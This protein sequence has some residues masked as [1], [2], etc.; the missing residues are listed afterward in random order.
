MKSLISLLALSPFLMAAAGAQESRPNGAPAPPAGVSPQ[1]QNLLSGALHGA[2]SG[3]PIVPTTFTPTGKSLLAE[4]MLAH[5]NAEEAQ[6]Q[7]MRA[8]VTQVSGLA[9][10]AYQANGFARNDLGVALAGLLDVCYELDQGT[11]K[12]TPS[13]P[14]EAATDKR[15]IQAAARQMQRALGSAPDFKN[16]SDQ[17]RQLAYEYCAF[18]TGHLAVNWQQAGQ[19]QAKQKAVRQL[20]RQQVQTLFKLS[21]ESLSRNAEGE[22]VPKAGT[23]P[24]EAQ[25]IH[26]P[27]PSAVTT[28]T[29]AGEM[30]TS[31]SAGKVERG[32]QLQEGVYVGDQFYGKE[33]RDRYR[34]YL[35][36][37]GQYRIYD[38]AGKLLSNNLS[39]F[40]Y[41]PRTG[42]LD[43][44]HG[45]IYMIFNGSDPKE[46]YCFYGRADGKPFVVASSDRGFSLARVLLQY[47][48]PVDKPSPQAEE[49]AKAAAEA[50]AKRYKWV[51][52]AGQGLKPSQV[53][54][55][56]L[57]QDLHQFYNGSG[58]SV[59]M[60]YDLYL[61]LNDGT[62]Y[63]GLP[64]SP[65]EMDVSLSRRKEPEKW[66][67]WKR[68]GDA[69]LAAWP[70]APNQFKPIKGI[71]VKPGAAGQK[72]SGRFGAGESSGSILGSS[73]RL[74]GVTFTPDGHFLKDNRGGYGS[75]VTA[76]NSGMAAIHS[77]YDDN[78]SSASASGE[79]FVVTS[80]RKQAP[81]GD[82]GGTYTLD[83]YTLTLHYD[84][85]HTARLPF[86]FKDEKQAEIWFEG[87]TLSRDEKAEKKK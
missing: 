77:N 44:S 11:F 24:A 25:P 21:P 27:A 8:Y 59:S 71:P 2:K 41:D 63:N 55:I 48:G 66:G 9:E 15:R 37:D 45:R 1:L 16:I 30:H 13:S 35:Y 68:Q 62:V 20:A 12:L 47:E 61:L 6:K 17:N 74:W 5:L 43:L 69:Y 56:L 22:F 64:V 49:Q 82:R 81:N 40:E 34:L 79:H 42:K 39:T 72:L 70:D 51:V 31:P 78:G 54:G 53:A 14:E 10:Q 38:K 67:H 32:G 52:P 3:A 18:M 4:A 75:S 85:G 86:F 87:N 23:P 26:S 19:D 50:E 36:K 57:H 58:L 46:D 84:N 80:G 76:Q 73:Y 29:P 60:T 83:G 28:K 33:M 65:D 7:Q